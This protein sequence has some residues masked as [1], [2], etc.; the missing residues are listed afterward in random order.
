MAQNNAKQPDQPQ[1]ASTLVRAVREGVLSSVEVVEACLKQIDLHEENIGA[2]AFIDPELVLEQA[3]QADE[4]RH[5]GLALGALHGIPVGIKDIIDTADMPTEN[6]T[7]LHSGRTPAADASLVAQLRTAGAIIMGKTVTAEL[8]TAHPGKTR[9]PHNIEHSPGGSSSGS[10][11]AVAADMVPLAV[12]TQTG[13]SVIR[14]ASFCG[15]YGYKPSFGL[16][17]RYRVLSQSPCLDTIGVFGRSLEDLALIG[18]TLMGFDA[19]DQ[20]MRPRARPQ[21]GVTMAEEPPMEPYLAFVRTP[22]WDEAE[23]TTKDAFKELVD[24]VSKHVDILELPAL[25]NDA[26]T[27]HATIMVADIA[28]SYA[29]LYRDGRDKLSPVL[30]QTIEQGQKILAVDYNT[31]LE[32]V[33]EFDEAFDD[34]FV[35]YDAILTPAAVGEAQVFDDTTGNPV[36][37]KLWTL[38]G[39]PAI[40]LPVL[41]GPNGLPIGAQ[42][43]SQKGDD[44]RLF[45]TARWLL[46]KL[47]E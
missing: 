30:C 31:A 47:E 28:K 5:R 11:A 13:G 46:N 35:E 32:R 2:W 39:T 36:F 41:Q 38:C 45:R 37:C 20:A 4:A 14:P 43:V 19:R 40:N 8:A 23:E 6:G 12:G 16:I 7:V 34:I 24:H 15:I 3:R 25:F 1:T 17:S 29:R 27:V 22:V 42:I 10:A 9:N 18:E 21:L 44:A 26:H 33:V